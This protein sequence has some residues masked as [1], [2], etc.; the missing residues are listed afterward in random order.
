ML[1]AECLR[2]RKVEEQQ[3]DEREQMGHTVELLERELRRILDEN[4]A[5][6]DA[7][8]A[9]GALP[10]LRSP[11]KDVNR[12]AHEAKAQALNSACRLFDRMLSHPGDPPTKCPEGVSRAAVDAAD[13]VAAKMLSERSAS[14][15][16]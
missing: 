15:A 10:L 16:A 2:L 11:L 9:Q 3:R 14:R 4:K 12:T 13:Q 7:A 1:R 6:R 8:Q 5:L